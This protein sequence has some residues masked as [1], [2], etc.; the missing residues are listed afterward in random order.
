MTSTLT[1]TATTNSIVDKFY[2]GTQDSTVTV[3][4]NTNTGNYI[5]SQ[6][7]DLSTPALT[8]DYTS[9]DI[10]IENNLIVKGNTTAINITQV[11]IEDPLINVGLTNSN[12]ILGMY[13]SG[14][15][16]TATG[17]LQYAMIILQNAY[18]SANMVKLIGVTS[19]LNGTTSTQYAKAYASSLVTSSLSNTGVC[20]FSI[21]ANTV[22]SSSVSNFTIPTTTY[23]T[24]SMFTN[25]AFRKGSFY[26]STY[27]TT[28]TQSAT[29]SSQTAKVNIHL[30]ATLDSAVSASTSITTLNYLNSWPTTG[31]LYYRS[32]TATAA[33][34]QAASAS[35]STATVSSVYAIGT[36]TPTVNITYTASITTP[37][38]ATVGTASSYPVALTAS[39]GSI[40]YLGNATYYSTASGYTTLYFTDVFLPTNVA[41]GSNMYLLTSAT[42]TKT[43]NQTLTLG[44]SITLAKESLKAQLFLSSALASTDLF[45]F[46][47]SASVISSIPYDLT[48]QYY[49]PMFDVNPSSAVSG[50]TMNLSNNLILNFDSSVSTTYATT[51]TT[52]SSLLGGMQT[53]TLANSFGIQWDYYS[54]TTDY[55]QSITLGSSGDNLFNFNGSNANKFQMDVANKKLVLPSNGYIQNDTSTSLIINSGGKTTVSDVTASTS[56]TTGA[57]VVSG[58]VGIATKLNVGGATTI[59][60]ATASTSTTTGALVVS[61]GVGIA[62]KL[63]VGGATT[64]TDATASTSTTTGALVVSGGVG[65]ATKLNVGGATTITDATASTSTTTGALVVSGGVGIATKLNVGGATTITDATASTSTTT[66]AL[67]V[68]GGVGIAGILNVGGATSLTGATKISDTTISTSTTTGALIVSGGVGI[69]GDLFARIVNGTF[70][71]S[72]DQRLKENVEDI[73]NALEKV[74]NLNGVYFNWIDKEK[75]GPERNIGFIAQNVESVVPELIKQ[76]GDGF[77]AVNYSQITG[78]LVEAIKEQSV[79]ISLLQSRLTALEDNVSDIASEVGS[80][81]SD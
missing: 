13:Q 12:I 38:L 58:G 77:Y 21:T 20:A 19:T 14:N 39:D 54:G 81:K 65:I 30:C 4:L 27:S 31:T 18:I 76:N 25:S 40:F 16:T 49:A 48:S 62:T 36:T 33:L 46:T 34:S 42:F 75:Y 52:T 41:L 64:I 61:G 73:D 35:S 6:G 10:T 44:S 7:A 5:I 67:I 71:T 51:F 15:T 68:S 80:E 66:G 28:Y 8:V 2:S 78:L 23:F 70:V 9:G 37:T 26:L 24:S 72:S 53:N 79:L 45:Y 56:T 3:G 74:L 47:D 63:N 43:S 22:A 32:P 57:L 69:A 1:R 50:T 60:D 29:S 55:S 17:Y 59:T 11:D